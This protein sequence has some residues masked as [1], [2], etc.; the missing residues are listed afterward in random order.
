MATTIVRSSWTGTRGVAYSG[1][2]GDWDQELA[3]VEEHCSRFVPTD[4]TAKVVERARNWVL[5]EFKGCLPHDSLSEEEIIEL[6]LN[7]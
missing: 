6:Y 5:R 1:L 7:N 3:L 2:S 4:Y